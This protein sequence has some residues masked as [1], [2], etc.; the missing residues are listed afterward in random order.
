MPYSNTSGS[1]G[2]ITTPHFVDHI[3]LCCS[4]KIRYIIALS[5]S[6]Y[7][8]TS[9]D[10]GITEID[11]ATGSIYFGVPRVDRHHHIIQNTHSPLPSSWSRALL[12]SFRTSTPFV[13][14][15]MAGYIPSYDLT[16]FLR[17][18][19]WNRSFSQIPFGYHPRCGRVF[20]MG[21]LR[22][23]PTVSPPRDQVNSEMRLEAIIERD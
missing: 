8:Y 22:S 16:L 4:Y 10:T 12:P 19:S 6:L 9:R 5:M 11:S 3:G 1:Q 17:C 2:S 13:W 23:S 20:Q 21:G 7:I 14:F 15:I 18:S